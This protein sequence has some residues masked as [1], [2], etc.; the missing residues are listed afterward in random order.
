MP[1]PLQDPSLHLA[2]LPRLF[3]VSQ[4]QA[5]ESI[6]LSLLERLQQKSSGAFLSITRT[7]GEISI[8]GEC[9]GAEED[10]AGADLAKAKATWRC[11]KI[12]GPMSFGLTG[13]MA[14]LTA[15]LKQAK[16][17]IFALSTWNTDYILV[18]ENKIDRAV[19][20]LK[21]DGWIFL[22]NAK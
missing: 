1:P 3:F 14:D 13:V 20:A 10:S 17:P 16:I 2:V 8:V 22:A 11:I 4:Q 15:P 18:P 21:E 19:E 6:P 12:A 7:S 9:L 5:D